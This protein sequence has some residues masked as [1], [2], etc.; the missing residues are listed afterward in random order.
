VCCNNF[1][2]RII[3]IIIR[4]IVEI[5]ATHFWWSWLL[6]SMFVFGV[7]FLCFYVLVNWLFVYVS[8]CFVSACLGLF[9]S[10]HFGS[11]TCL[12]LV[13]FG[14][15]WFS[16]LWFNLFGCWM[17]QDSTHNWFVCLVGQVLTISLF[18]G[19]SAHILVVW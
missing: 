18:G 6:G 9:S 14:L 5:V 19:L 17:S 2:P 3:S 16:F 11:S 13:L 8:G 10:I 7:S 1:F 15:V 12:D 4:E